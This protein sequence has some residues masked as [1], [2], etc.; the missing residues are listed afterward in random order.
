MSVAKERRGVSW[1]AGKATVALRWAAAAEVK[2][3][4][5]AREGNESAR[6]ERASA[7]QV[8]AHRGPTWP[9]WVG[10]WR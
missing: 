4:E 9:D 1:V 3:N 5:K 2:A 7:G 6:S 10:H 8:K